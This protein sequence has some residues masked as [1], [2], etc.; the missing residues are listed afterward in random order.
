MH[1]VQ[2]T[3]KNASDSQVF[4]NSRDQIRLYEQIESVCKDGRFDTKQCVRSL[5]SDKHTQL[6]YIEKAKL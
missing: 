3:T 4:G 5:Q 1:A 6:F 2:L